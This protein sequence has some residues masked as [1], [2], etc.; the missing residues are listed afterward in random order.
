VW[1]VALAVGM[2]AC[3]PSPEPLD[4]PSQRALEIF[5]LARDGEPDDTTVDD[6]FDARSDAMWR[7]RL[8]DSL[9]EL[10]R[11]SEP[12]IEH[13]ETLEELHRKVVVITGKLPGEG[14]GQYEVQ[15]EQ[16]EGNLWKIVSFSGPGVSWPPRQ[17][18]RDDGLSTRPVP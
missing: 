7:A 6:L 1:P 14:E 12:S 15:V 18:G 9:S 16:R 10:V 5:A 3:A 4:E 2:L 17:A 11:V 13:T 8:F